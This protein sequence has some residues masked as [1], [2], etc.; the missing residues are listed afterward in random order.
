M[1]TEGPKDSLDWK[2]IGDSSKNEADTG[3]VVKKRL[4]R[5]MRHIP[6]YYFLPRRSMFANIAIYGSCIV[7]GIGAG[8]LTEIWINK[9]IKV[10]ET[11]A[12]RGYEAESEY[13]HGGNEQVEERLFLVD[14]SLRKR[15]PFGFGF[16]LEDVLR[17]LNITEGGGVSGRGGGSRI[18]TLGVPG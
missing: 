1:G 4:P 13:E 7:G 8:M 10:H 9:K 18:P 15:P 16:L 17:E 6:D 11:G 12:T 14:M 5:K 3:P 2:T